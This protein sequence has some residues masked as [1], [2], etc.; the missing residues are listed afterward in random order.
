[1]NYK[2]ITYKRI[3]NLGNFE[4]QHLELTAEVDENEDIDAAIES[5]KSKVHQG[6]GLEKPKDKN[7]DDI[8]F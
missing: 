5:L 2:T 4:S 8:D 6:L 3:K 7:D 1:M